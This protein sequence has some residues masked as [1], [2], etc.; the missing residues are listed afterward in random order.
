MTDRIF[1]GS[2]INSFLQHNGQLVGLD[3]GGTKRLEDVASVSDEEKTQLIEPVGTVPVTT[4]DVEDAVEETLTESYTCPCKK[5]SGSCG[6]SN[7]TSNGSAQ[8]AKDIKEVWSKFTSQ[9]QK[10]TF[11]TGRKPRNMIEKLDKVAEDFKHT[12]T[13]GNKRNKNV[14]E[15]FCNEHWHDVSSSIII[16]IVIVFITLAIY[17]SLTLIKITEKCCKKCCGVGCR[18]VKDVVKGGSFGRTLSGGAIF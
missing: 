7:G 3:E 8:P 9:T 6:S 10:D 11:S 14:V 5:K 4:K 1:P 17:V 15:G 13:G 12:L 2:S 18:G 16:V